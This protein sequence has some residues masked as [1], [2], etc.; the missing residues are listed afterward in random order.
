MKGGASQH[1]WMI[2]PASDTLPGARGHGFRP[3]AAPAD[4]LRGG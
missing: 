4:S 2:A 1:L 3:P